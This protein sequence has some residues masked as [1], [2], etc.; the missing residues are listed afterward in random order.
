[1]DAP[2]PTPPPTPPTPSTPDTGRKP[3]ASRTRSYGGSTGYP[4]SV[5]RL[6][7]ELAHLPGIGRRSAERLTFHILKATEPEAM[8]L[9]NA[10]AEV[11]RR[12]RHCIVCYNLMDASAT[13]PTTPTPSSAPA[14]R[15]CSICADN[16]RDR[17]TV[18]VVEQPKDLI[19]LEQ[20]ATYSGLYHILMGRISPLEGVSAADL[21]VS[22]LLHRVDDPSA[23][24]SA[25]IREIIL[26]L[27]P[28]LEGDGTGLY[29]AQELEGRNVR[30]T[31]LARGLPT[32]STLEFASKAVLAD[33][34]EGRKPM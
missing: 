18:M 1:M 6:I 31:R 5:T 8:A 25:P 13:P 16:T 23:N 15:L 24:I 28:T 32:G 22:D 20:T 12:V 7:D 30:V 11:K 33:A 29:L 4:E 9:S 10:I 34:I 14:P 21:T 17:A 3:A 19:A 27:N 2:T 26:A